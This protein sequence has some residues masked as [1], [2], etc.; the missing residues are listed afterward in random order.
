[1]LMALMLTGCG[2]KEDEDTSVEAEEAAE[3]VSEETEQESED[4][5]AGESEEGEE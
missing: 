3:E 2:E 4:T 5:S 1:M